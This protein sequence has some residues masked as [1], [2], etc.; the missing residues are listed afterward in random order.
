MVNSLL[1]RATPVRLTRG[2]LLVVLGVFAVAAVAGGIGPLTAG[3]VSNALLIALP[4]SA[5]VC[6]AVRAASE[7]RARRRSWALIG[8]A[9][10]SWGAGQSIWTFYEQVLHR[11]VPFPSYADVGYLGFI[12]LVLLGLVLMPYAEL[13]VAT[14]V[15]M[16]L[17]GLVI[18][19]SILLVSWALILQPTL[20]GASDGWLAKTISVAY[21]VGDCVAITLALVIVARARHGSELRMMTILMLA[22]GILAFGVGDTGFLVGTQSGTYASGSPIDLGWAA[23]FTLIGIAATVRG[24]AAETTPSRHTQRLSLLAPYGAV[25]VALAVVGVRLG[26][27][28]SPDW[29]S[30]TLLLGALALVVGRQVLTM[31]ENDSLTRNLE[32]RVE[33]R[34]EQLAS[35]E[36]WFASLVHNSTDVILVLDT[37]GVIDFQTPSA[38]RIF[39]Y[40][41]DALHGTGVSSIVAPDEAVRLVD[42]LHRLAEQPLATST[43]DLTLRHADGELRHTETTITSLVHDPAVAGFVVTIRDVTERRRLEQQ[44]M[45]QAFHDELTGLAN[46]ALFADRVQRALAA[47]ARTAAPLAVIFID[48][49]SFKSVNDSLGHGC[50]DELLSQVAQRLASCVRPGDTVAR[51]GGDEFAVLVESMQNEDEALEV[52]RRF[53]QALHGGFPVAGREVLI[54]ASMGVAV[55][56]SGLEDVEEMLRNA[57]LAMYQAKAKREGGYEV[58]EPAMHTSA[59]TRLEL[60]NDLRRALRRGEFHLDYQPTIELVSGHLTGVEALLRWNH[61]TRGNVPPLEFVSTAEDIGLINEIGAW[62]IEEACRQA[63]TWQGINDQ[64]FSVAVNISGRQLNSSLV[65]QIR[66]ALN[67]HGIERGWLTLE[68]T[69]SVLIHHTDEVL[70]WLRELRA[71]GVKIAIDDF[72]TGY[73]SLSYLSRMPVDVLKLDRSFVEQ[74]AAGTQSVELTRTIVALAQTLQL[75][76]VAEGIEADDQLGELLDMGC[77]HGQG[78]LFSKPVSAATIAAM[79]HDSAGVPLPRASD[80]VAD[81]VVR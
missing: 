74:V 57:D 51:F 35:R 38:L 29:F 21:P 78:F 22:A 54:R 49:D 13:A 17:D 19:V 43:L 69:E 70:E 11:G 80:T 18:G 64:P 8:G 3:V 36:R 53:R 9:A 7:R 68:M 65:G 58:Y 23:G 1:G 47:C 34:T 67:R 50:G 55:N 59:L 4:L 42:V 32:H 6:C 45:H 41:E 12:P 63:K 31:F 44:L 20:S 27:G 72:G 16:L 39:G 75:S 52:A 26:R 37:D 76:T 5:A 24:A 79:L 15:R 28:T 14:R 46:K 25:V 61:P 60:E 10:L 71:M 77:S 66:D 48:L 40:A 73:S 2:V 30:I 56:R 33:Q 62:V 81:A